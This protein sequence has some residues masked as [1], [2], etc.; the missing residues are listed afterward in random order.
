MDEEFLEQHEPLI[1]DLG[2][3]YIER[4]EY[5]LGKKYIN[6]EHEIYPTL[7]PAQF[8]EL[9]T[10][11]NLQ[12]NELND[13]YAEFIKLKPSSHLRKILD[14]FHASG[15]NID[16]EPTFNEETKRL[17]VL[18][19]FV[20]KD[21]VLNKI[22]GLTPIEDVLL[23]INALLQIDQVLSGSDGDMAPSF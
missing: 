7:T 2:K 15:G 1:V 22:E 21:T 23:R 4:M 17:H 6:K 14:A 18:V 19:Q 5:E 12:D 8:M 3:A 10:S 9:K 16:I 20:I 11:Y 13:I